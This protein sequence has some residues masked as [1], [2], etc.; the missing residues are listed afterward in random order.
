[1]ETQGSTTI[2]RKWLW[3]FSSFYQFSEEDI[4]KVREKRS[5]PDKICIRLKENQDRLGVGEDV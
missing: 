3:N 1:M 2:Y 5:L 4:G